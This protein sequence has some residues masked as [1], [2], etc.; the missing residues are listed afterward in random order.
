VIS[1][2]SKVF[3]PSRGRRQI[4]RRAWSVLEQC[5]RKLGL[6]EIPLPIPVDQW[7]EAPLG[8]GFG[9]ADLSYLG[10]G[11][12]GAA[13]VE[14]KEILID[15]RVLEHEGRFRFTCAHE[16][17]HMVLHRSV[18]KAFHDAGEFMLPEEG[19]RYERQADRF[20]AALL[21]PIPLL[22]R[23]L[24]YVMD[25]QNRD[26]ART[27]IALMEPTTESV[28]IWRRV[29]LPRITRAFDVSLT[30]A[31]FR[32]TDLRPKLNCAGPLLPRDIVPA[33]LN[34]G[35]PASSGLLF[36]Q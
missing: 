1:L 16:L 20:A 24:A 7:I 32:F 17:G 18:K 19:N 2:P 31:I 27:T 14:D 22:E 8:I 9:C 4:E 29:I 23:E 36:G 12:L 3:E 30:A 11:V 15:E 21:M 26:R 28:E 5:R 13:F 34:S 6:Q 33:L 35:K 25:D 10:T